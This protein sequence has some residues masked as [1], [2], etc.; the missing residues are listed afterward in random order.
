MITV[1]R[2][3]G[4]VTGRID[5]EKAWER[6]VENYMKICEDEKEEEEK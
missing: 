6:I 1:N 4:E 2:K 5:T 3:T